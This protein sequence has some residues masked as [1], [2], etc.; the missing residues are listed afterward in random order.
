[1]SAVITE[2]RPY[3][4]A[5]QQAQRIGVPRAVAVHEVAEERRAGRT[6]Q[7]VAW[8]LRMTAMGIPAPTGPGAA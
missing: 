2:L 1:M 8:A 5:V 3:Q 7:A 6:G 4:N